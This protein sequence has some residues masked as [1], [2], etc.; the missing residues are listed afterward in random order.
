MGVLRT[1]IYNTATNPLESDKI[2]FLYLMKFFNG[3]VSTNYKFEIQQKQKKYKKKSPIFFSY[4]FFSRK[5]HFAGENSEEEE[6]INLDVAPISVT[7]GIEDFKYL[8][9]YCHTYM[10]EKNWTTLPVAVGAL[11]EMV[12]KI[13]FSLFSY[14][15]SLLC[16]DL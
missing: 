8:L 13:S 5:V 9:H 4:I 3:Y 7:F 6:T 12:K 14:F 1:E 2:N 10:D 11:K 16:L 15:F